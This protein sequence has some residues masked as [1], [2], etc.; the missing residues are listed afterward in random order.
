MTTRTL[1]VSSIDKLLRDQELTAELAQLRRCVRKKKACC[2]GKDGVQVDYNAAKL[3]IF[4]APPAKFKL[5]LASLRC[6]N[7]RFIMAN[8]EFRERSA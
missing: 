5:I 3:I 8:G 4:T 2:G 7:L 1:D 6:D